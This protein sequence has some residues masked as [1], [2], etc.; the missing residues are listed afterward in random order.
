MSFRRKKK[1]GSAL[2]NVELQTDEVIRQGWLLKQGNRIKTWKKRWMVLNRAFLLYF[3]SA[4]VKESTQPQ[5]VIKIAEIRKVQIADV[6]K[7]KKFGFEI[8]T[9]NRTY[10]MAADSASVRKAWIVS[11]LK[12]VEENKAMRAK[13]KKG[14]AQ[15]HKA[16]L[17]SSTGAGG[18]AKAAPWDPSGEDYASGTMIIV[19]NSDDDDDSFDAGTMVINPGGGRRQ[20]RE[21]PTTTT[22]TFTTPAPWCSTT[23]TMSPAP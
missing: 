6:H 8:H 16:L 2:K 19:A 17:S 12:A 10:P 14:S 20:A 22:T 21:Q 11:I 15:L 1:L 13:V 9:R 23:R 3:K 18:K 4:A 7:R 5:G